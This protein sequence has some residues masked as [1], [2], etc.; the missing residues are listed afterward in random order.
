MH[1]PPNEI[2]IANT[3]YPLVSAKGLSVY[4]LILLYRAISPVLH[5]RRMTSEC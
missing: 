3:T 2:T 1:K 4:Q 5:N